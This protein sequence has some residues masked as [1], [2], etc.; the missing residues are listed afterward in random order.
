MTPELAHLLGVVAG[1]AFSLVLFLT[2][3]VYVAWRLAAKGA[4]SLSVWLSGAPVAWWVRLRSMKASAF[5]ERKSARISR[6]V[7][8][9]PPAGVSAFYMRNSSALPLLRPPGRPR[10]QDRISSPGA[11]CGES[12]VNEAEAVTGARSERGAALITPFIA[13]GYSSASNAV[14]VVV[15]GAQVPDPK[16][17]PQASPCGQ[18]T[19]A[20]CTRGGCGQVA[21][22]RVVHIH[23]GKA[24]C[25]HPGAKSQRACLS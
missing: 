18:G 12:R 22:R 25:P 20:A 2:P 6:L 3:A 17:C 23:V 19:C 16:G 15:G 9:A 21:S 7:R 14:V 11:R 13:S 4:S 5:I 8:H 1:L 10:H 24:S